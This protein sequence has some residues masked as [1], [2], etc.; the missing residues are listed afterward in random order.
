MM[1][2]FVTVSLLCADYFWRV[3]IMPFQMF[4]MLAIAVDLAAAALI[5]GAYRIFRNRME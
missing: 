2:M 4:L 3:L 1:A 5:W